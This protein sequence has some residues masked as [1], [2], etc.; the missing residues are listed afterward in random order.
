MLKKLIA[1]GAAGTV[2]AAF[3]VPALAAT[4]SISVADDVFKPKSTTVSKG[5]TVRFR[6]TGKNPHNVVRTSGPSFS[7]IGTRTKGSVSRKLSKKGTYKLVC[8]I[9]PGMNLTIRVR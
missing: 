9:H 2:A 7:Q 4:K 8:S 1:V 5:T 6:W 3:A